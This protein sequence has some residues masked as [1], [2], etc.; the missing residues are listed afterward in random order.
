MAKIVSREEAV[1]LVKD[2]DYVL[3]GGFRAALSTNAL[4]NLA[5]WSSL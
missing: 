5:R 1:S 4:K 2:G 3:I